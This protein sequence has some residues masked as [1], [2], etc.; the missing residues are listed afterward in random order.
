[1]EWTITIK[2]NQYAEIITRGIAD[3]SG[4]LDMAKAI[5]MTMSEHK[6]KKALIDHSNIDTVS[7]TIVDVYERPKQFQEL[8]VARGLKIAEVVKSEH[9]EFFRF[10]ETVSVNDGFGFAM[11]SDRQSAL[12]WLLEQ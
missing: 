2:E 5:T 9:K 12:E 7:G 11:F 1:M 3:R 8:G 6:I 10:L 4:S